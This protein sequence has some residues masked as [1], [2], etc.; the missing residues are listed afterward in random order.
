MPSPETLVIHGNSRELVSI[1]ICGRG[2]GEIARLLAS[3]RL[4]SLTEADH[5]AYARSGVNIAKITI[6]KAKEEPSKT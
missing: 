1:E 2:L 4:V 3:Q 6:N 5:P